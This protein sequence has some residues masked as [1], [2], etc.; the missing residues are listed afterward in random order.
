MY[1]YKAY[2]PDKKIVEGPIDAASE[3]VAEARL[4]SA[5]YDHVLTLQKTRSS[6]HLEQ[7]LQ[8]S[9]GVNRT[10]II[11]LFQQLATLIGSRMPVTQALGLLAEQAPR[12][13]LKE[14]VNRLGQE[15]PR[16][17]PIS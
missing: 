9:S 6:F 7:I 13:P 8:W 1:Q 5:G 15:I 2:T 14:I 16:G 12:A 3:A 17:S 11:D 4:R 10:D